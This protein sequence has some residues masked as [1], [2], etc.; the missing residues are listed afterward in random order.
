MHLIELI[1]TIKERRET[2][3]L[4]QESLAEISGVG[5]RTLK[6]LESGEGNPTVKTL[7]KL[8]DV[9]GMELKLV[10]KQNTSIK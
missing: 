1:N 9:L 2:L 10:V 6:Q 8:S 3:S 4:S 7:E 5:L